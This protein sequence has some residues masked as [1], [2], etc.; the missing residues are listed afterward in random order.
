MAIG[1]EEDHT[2]IVRRDFRGVPQ[3]SQVEHL[4]GDCL[5][6]Y[7]AL[8]AGATVAEREGP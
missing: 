6:A 7:E 4:C 5:D 2:E 3:P 8:L 1:V